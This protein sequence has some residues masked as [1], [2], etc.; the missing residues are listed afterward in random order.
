MQKRRISTTISAKHWLLLEKYT[1]KFETQQKALEYALENLENGG[2]NKVLSLEDMVR[3]KYMEFKPICHLHKDIFLELLRT[4]NYDQLGKLFIEMRVAEYQLLLC[5]QKPLKDMSLKEVVD[6]LVVTSR[7]GNWLES[8]ECKDDGK[9]Y[10]LIATHNAKDLKYSN[11]FKLF[12]SSLFES[13][14]VKTESTMTE[15]SLFMKIFKDVG[16]ERHTSSKKNLRESGNLQI[17][18]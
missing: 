10:T 2:H 18:L 17:V 4:A 13:Y 12:F 6:G 9:C 8:L 11:L 14:G 16:T 1:E 5:Y 3:W 7:A 15:H